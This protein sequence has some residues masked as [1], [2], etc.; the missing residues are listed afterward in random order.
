MRLVVVVTLSEVAMTE[1]RRQVDALKRVSRAATKYR[2]QRLD[3]P[4]LSTILLITRLTI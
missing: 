1:T 4:S 3:T 2:L